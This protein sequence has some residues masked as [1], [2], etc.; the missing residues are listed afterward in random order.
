MT[1]MFWKRPEIIKYLNKHTNDLFNIPDP[2]EQLLLIKKMINLH[3]IS[4]L[5]L[6]S[7]GVF[8]QKCSVTSALENKGLSENDARGK[9]I[10]MKRLGIH[11]EDIINKK[12][13]KASVRKNSSEDIKEVVKKAIEDNQ[14]CSY[15]SDTSV[16]LSDLTQDIIDEQ[17]LILFDISLLKR[18]NK[19]LFVFIDKNNHKKYWLVPF[20][21]RIYVSQSRGVI[22]N[23]YIENLTDTGFQEYIITDIK[24]YTRLKYMLG[25]SY[26]GL[27]NCGY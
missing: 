8:S 25:N 6:Y 9:A 7:S 23:D 14:T 3:G 21:A 15:K 10:M 16:Y 5:D 24:S 1:E 4:Q 26:K 17:E 18:Q 22:H 11:A 27:V 2:I 13:T 19:V 20:R 12:A